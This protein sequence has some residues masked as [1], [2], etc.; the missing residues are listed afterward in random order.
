MHPPGADTVL[1]RYGELNTKS[2]SVSAR[3]VDRLVAHLDSLLADRGL[4]GEI[5]TEPG[6]VFV[7][8]ESERVEDV[9]R[10]AADT[11]GVVSASPVL[12]VDPD[13]DAIE[14]ALVETAAACYDGGTYAVD[15]RRAFDDHPFTSEDVE[16]FGGNAVA[17]GAAA[18]V[19]PRVDLDDPDLTVGVEVRRED[20][21]VY[22]DR[23]AG[24]GGLPLGTQAP[25]VA[26]ISGGIDSPVAAHEIMSRGSPVVPVYLDLGAYGGVDHRTRALETVRRLSRYAP[27]EDWTLYE[28][29]TGET[30][31]RLVETLDRGRM[32]AFRRYMFQVATHVAREHDA[33]GIVTGESLGQKS[34]QTSRN[35]TV[36]SAA[37]DLPVHR[38]LL[39]WDKTEITERAREIGTFRES[40]IP[41]GCN[42]IAPDHPETNGSLDE[43]REREPTDLAERARRDAA[44]ADAVS[45]VSIPSSDR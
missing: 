42:R 3:M 43:I 18:D 7:K 8:T 32:L 2:R 27:D 29:P 39:T 34:S 19:E 36:T 38:P 24:P 17:A 44:R 15:A 22:V 30:V 35:L 23:V 11:F 31:D 33:C 9:A 1:V 41:A 45:A 28:V 5:R 21:F 4:P 20:A 37:T 25:V 13:R 6:R 14:T 16:V 26:L 12:P 10:A 40:S